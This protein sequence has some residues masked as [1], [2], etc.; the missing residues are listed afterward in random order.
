VAEARR[1]LSRVAA[2][3][4]CSADGK[5]LLCRIAQGATAASDGMWTLPG[6]GVDFG[7]DPSAAALRELTEETGLRGEIE[8]LLAVDSNTGSFDDPGDGTPTDY[9]GIRVVYR[10]RVT[11]GTLRD[12]TAGTTDACR[13]VPAQE[14]CDLPLVDL[15]RLGARLARLLP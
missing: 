14:L 7:E 12:E 1:R 6:G 13:W 3:A 11:G 2:Y 10:V 9:H 15:A 4:L 5:I 8:E